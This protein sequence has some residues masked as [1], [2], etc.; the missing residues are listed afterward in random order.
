MK[1]FAVIRVTDYNEPIDQAIKSVVKARHSFCGVCIVSNGGPGL[2]APKHRKSLDNVELPH[3]VVSKLGKIPPEADA[4]LE[5]PPQCDMDPLALGELVQATRE[6]KHDVYKTHFQL[7]TVFRDP[8][9]SLAYGWLLVLYMIELAWCS[10]EA[11][12]LPLDRY[13]RLTYVLR[14]GKERAVAPWQFSW[15]FRNTGVARTVARPNWVDLRAHPRLRGWG[16]VKNALYRHEFVGNYRCFLGNWWLTLWYL[17]YYGLV[18]QLLVRSR[19]LLL[20]YAALH[21][22]LTA[23][24]YVAMSRRTRIR[25][26]LWL[27]FLHPLYFLTFPV[28]ALIGRFMQ[29]HSEWRDTQ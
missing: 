4:V 12:K 23:F 8:D 3:T 6:A 19:T 17:F 26:L 25:G 18:V 22:G 16:L 24:M 7:S 27:C 13:V 5:I 21:I 2:L 11:F 29:P 9:V 20:L 28:V 15:R 10:Y 14:K 1:L